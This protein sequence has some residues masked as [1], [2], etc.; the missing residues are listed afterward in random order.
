ME[1]DKEKIEEEIN[2][3]NAT[4]DVFFDKCSCV[5]G[6]NGPTNIWLASPTPGSKEGP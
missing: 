2:E 6:E 5:T 4:Q 3:N 1:K